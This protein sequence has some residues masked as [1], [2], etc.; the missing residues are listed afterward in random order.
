MDKI[1][2]ERANCKYLADE[3]YR[4]YK[5]TGKEKWKKKA[6][7]QYAMFDGLTLQ[8]QNP[9]Q[10]QKIVNINTTVNSNN[11]TQKS[12]SFFSGN[13]NCSNKK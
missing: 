9:Q 10:S 7:K 11:N 13:K 5:E 4:K 6:S 8:L 12:N 2:T 1:I 3:Y